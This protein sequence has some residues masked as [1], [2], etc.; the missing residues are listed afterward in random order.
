MRMVDENLSSRSSSG[1]FIFH[2]SLQDVETVCPHIRQDMHESRYQFW[3]FHPTHVDT[4]Y[5]T[6]QTAQTPTRVYPC[7]V[8]AGANKH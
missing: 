4:R 8:H 7:S 6:M 3:T 1:H 2:K 5:T